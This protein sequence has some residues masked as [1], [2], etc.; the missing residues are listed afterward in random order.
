[1]P[2]TVK[3]TNICLHEQ[4]I[5]IQVMTKQYNY[6]LLYQMTKT[7]CLKGYVSN[8]S[9]KV[10]KKSGK[11][12]FEDMTFLESSPS[13]FSFQMAACI[14]HL[15]SRSKGMMM[16]FRGSYFLGKG[17]AGLVPNKC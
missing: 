6:V 5:P 7:R 1:M 12:K 13:G 9:I 8:W 14:I 11:N 10:A 2:K 16:T 3:K 4:V 17:A 15:Y